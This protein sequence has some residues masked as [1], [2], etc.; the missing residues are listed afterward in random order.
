MM[1]PRNISPE[2]AADLRVRLY[3]LLTGSYA[4]IIGKPLVAAGQGPTWLYNDAP[5]VVLA[6]NTE[7]PPRGMSFAACRR[8]WRPSRPSL[9]SCVTRSPAM[10]S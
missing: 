5:F 2:H 7:P 10:A 1:T 3:D 9:S 4:R 8:V 6:H